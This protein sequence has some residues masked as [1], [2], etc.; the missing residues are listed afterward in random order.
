VKKRKSP[1]SL[2][3][4]QQLE[5]LRAAVE[6]EP[7]SAQAHYRLGTALVQRGVAPEAEEA[8]RKATELDPEHVQA[9][10]NLGGLQLL[11]W[12]FEDCV[13]ANRKAAAVAP[14]LMQAHFNEGLGHLYL[15]NAEEMVACF[16]RVLELDPGNPAGEYHLAVGLLASD[17]V[18]EAQF[19]LAAAREKGYSPQPE[20]IKA[21]ER[22]LGGQVTTIELGDDSGNKP[23]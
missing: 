19:W 2:P 3:T 17:Q 23:S 22:R 9:W 15:G 1:K 18:D 16:R 21:I 6:Q 14:D 11:R 13:E 7:E 12:K 4:G 20:F 8:L 10:V 5:E